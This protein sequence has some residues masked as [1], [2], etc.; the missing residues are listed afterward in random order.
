MEDHCSSQQFRYQRLG[1]DCTR[2]L[3]AD[4][5]RCLAAHKKFVALGTESGALHILDGCGHEIR[6][7]SPHSAAIL[8]IC[9]DSTGEFVGSCSVDGTVVISSLFGGE[10]STHWYHRPVNAIA[11]DSEYATCRIFAAG[12]LACQLVICSRGWLGY[13]YAVVHS[14]E[15]PVTSIRIA[16]PMLAW[17]N[18]LVERSKTAYMTLGRGRRCDSVKPP[19]LQTLG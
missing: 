15:G 3:A 14:G 10:G 7:F 18:G 1:G 13:K 5:A 4:A 17:A 9:I 11:L 12:G 8:D 6:R 2:I 19:C 16:G